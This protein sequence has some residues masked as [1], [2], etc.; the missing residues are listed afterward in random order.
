M[1]RNM[2]SVWLSVFYPY[3][4]G[5]PDFDFGLVYKKAE[6]WPVIVKKAYK[7]DKK[8]EFLFSDYPALLWLGTWY[9]S[10]YQFFIDIW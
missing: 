4:V 9:P 7:L 6:K 5:A 8:S 10:G 3:L 2:V 1:V